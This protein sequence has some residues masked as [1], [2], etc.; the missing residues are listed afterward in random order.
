M[1]LVDV[2][3]HLG[4][5]AFKEDLNLVLER[6]SNQGISA[7]VSST[8]SMEEAERSID[9]STRYPHLVFT[10]IGSD[11]TQLDDGWVQPI[12]QMIKMNR[13]RIVGV[14]EVGLDHYWVREPQRREYQL[15]LFEKWI[16]LASELKLPLTVHSRSAGYESLKALASSSVERVLMHAYDGKVGHA[17]NAA[18]SGVAFSI[19]ASV[20][21]SE[22]KQKLARRLPIENLVLETD[23]PVLSPTKGQR[24]EPSNVVYSAVKVAELKRMDVESV[25]EITS[26]NAIRL[27]DLSDASP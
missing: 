2:H 12:I 9:I 25:A 7:I 18:E 15:K 1:N 20:I 22:Q 14:G 23:A 27:F 4:D 6:A 5:G 3:C 11:P 13:T 17:M 24:N 19:P 16:T 10:S 26:R 8:V 21:Y